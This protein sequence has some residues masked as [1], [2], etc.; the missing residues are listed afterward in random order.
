[1]D[2]DENGPK[3]YNVATISIK[4]EIQEAPTKINLLGD[5]SHAFF[6]T[7]HSWVSPEAWI[8][9]QFSKA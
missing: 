7:P 3:E 9:T 5:L 4:R 1:M 6:Q 2:T 8:G